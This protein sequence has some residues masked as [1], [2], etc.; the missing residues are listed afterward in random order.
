MTEKVNRK[1]I[2]RIYAMKRKKK[3]RQ[4]KKVDF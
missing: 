4:L 2:D 1:K 3:L